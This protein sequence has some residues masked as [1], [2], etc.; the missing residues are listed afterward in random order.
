MR[1][2]FDGNEANV[3]ERVGVSVYTLE[4]LRY[5]SQ[6]NTQLFDIFLRNTPLSHLPQSSPTLSYHVVWGPALWSRLFLPLSL[7]KKKLSCF[8][9]PAHYAPAFLNIPLVVTIHD[10]SFFSFPDEFRKRDLIKLQNWTKESV[11]KA[12]T[13]IAVSKTTKKDIIKRYNIPEEKIQVVYNGF[14]KH[15]FLP[16]VSNQ[17]KILAS[18]QIESK[19]YLLY[20][21]TIQPRKNLTTLFQAFVQLRHQYP[22]LKLVIAGKHGWMIEKTLIQIKK[23]NIEENLVFTGYIPDEELATLYSHA[24]CLVFPS[25]YEGFGIPVLEAFSFGCPVVASFSSSLPEVGG[26]GCLYADPLKPSEFAEKISKII[27]HKELRTELRKKAKDQLSLF[28]WKTCGKETLK[29]LSQYE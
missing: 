9:S 15:S 23:L 17:K 24:R 6:Q 19:E 2:G 1:I 10:L 16:S 18:Y 25:L 8:F 29:I 27:S 12:S 22:N 14:E 26:S 20:V 21:G 11:E 5:F 7:M 28:S 3:E 4:L 13:I